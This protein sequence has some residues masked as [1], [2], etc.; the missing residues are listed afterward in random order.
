MIGSSDAAAERAPDAEALVC[1]GRRLTLRAARR[2]RPI[3]VA[4]GLRSLGVRRGDRVA[5]H[6]EN[7]V[8]AVLSILGAL[9]AGAAFV[10]INPTT[11]GEKLGYMLRDSGAVAAGVGPARRA[12]GRRGPRRPTRRSTCRR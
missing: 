8:E 5:I 9:R 10:P 3:G 4:A 1:G 6:L 7:S 2:A 11:K 12:D